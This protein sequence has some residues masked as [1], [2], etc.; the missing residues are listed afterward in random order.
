MSSCKVSGNLAVQLQANSSTSSHSGRQFVPGMCQAATCNVQALSACTVVQ[1]QARLPQVKNCHIRVVAAGQAIFA[2]GPDTTAG[3]CASSVVSAPVTFSSHQAVSQPSNNSL[4]I[5]LTGSD[6]ATQLSKG[7]MPSTVQPIPSLHGFKPAAAPHVD[8]SSTSNGFTT[9]TS[10]SGTLPSHIPSSNPTALPKSFLS[11]PSTSNGFCTSA[12]ASVPTG[13]NSSSTANGLIGLAMQITASQPQPIHSRSVK[14]ASIQLSNSL[15]SSVYGASPASYNLPQP[16][17]QL[18]N[19]TIA[20][21]NTQPPQNLP[22]TAAQTAASE[23]LLDLWDCPPSGSSAPSGQSGSAYMHIPTLGSLPVHGMDC[24][25]SGN[26]RSLASQ[27]RSM[28]CQG[29]KRH[30]SACVCNA[31]QYQHAF[32]STVL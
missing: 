2:K 18:S 29:V 6:Q 27:A 11:R 12:A 13:S 25:A 15:Q 14:P 5:Q 10:S 26:A 21:L 1:L 28:S 22:A 19:L 17:Q 20:P 16:E 23:A 3:V 8:T 7:L 31:G 30:F 24:S 32:T 9:A 4:S